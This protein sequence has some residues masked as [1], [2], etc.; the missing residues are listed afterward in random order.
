M[1]YNNMETCLLVDDGDKSDK[2][3]GILY[4]CLFYSNSAKVLRHVYWNINFNKL[5]TFDY[6]ISCSC[7]DKLKVHLLENMRKKMPEFKVL[8][9]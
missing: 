8:I 9:N 1:I 3:I 4:N 7:I 6:N 5:C 2:C